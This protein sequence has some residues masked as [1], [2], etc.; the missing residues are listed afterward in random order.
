MIYKV[1]GGEII[2]LQD[3]PAGGITV[4]EVRAVEYVPDPFDALDR[5]L[6]ALLAPEPH[7][8]DAR[9]ELVAQ[10]L[11]EQLSGRDARILARALEAPLLRLRAAVGTDDF[12]NEREGVLAVDAAFFEVLGEI[13]PASDVEALRSKKRAQ[14]D[15]LAPRVAA[16][17]QVASPG[18]TLLTGQTWI[19]AREGSHG[20]ALVAAWGKWI[21]PTQ[22]LD[23][24]ARALWSRVKA[25][26]DA[27]GGAALPSEALSQIVEATLPVRRA[28]RSNE[29]QGRFEVILRDGRVV[30]QVD[31][32]DVPHARRIGPSLTPEVVEA[33]VGP[34]STVLAQRVFRW[35][36]SDTFE[37]WTAAP[38]GFRP[39]IVVPN[40]LQ[41]LAERVGATGGKQAAQLPEVLDALAALRVDF[42]GT[43]DARILHWSRSPHAPGRPA[44]VVIYPGD[45]LRPGWASSLSRKTPGERER[46]RL[47]PIPR[48]A[49]PPVLDRRL[50]AAE[51]G[52]ALLTMQLLA[53][54]ARQIAEGG[55]AEITDAEWRR[56]ADRVEL[57]RG[58]M[59]RVVDA[60]KQGEGRF[61]ELERNRW[62]LGPAYAT[63]W[64]H[65]QTLGRIRER[66]A[67]RGELISRRRRG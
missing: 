42:N 38:R 40:G 60:W 39:E 35:L 67:Q 7:G 17:R 52:L 21:E 43:G 27:K 9:S 10:A 8:L 14:W 23:F 61:L 54:R 31:A 62:R 26:L 64:K 50:H 28:R 65:L 4:S 49:P 57:D 33:L 11:K 47:V 22:R 20:E 12:W 18:G 13:M 53:E 66:A 25:G 3:L 30:A 36:V 2:I 59:Y 44:E 55:A 34:T 24:L 48:E 19:V 37:R 45:A 63:E 5:T 51:G 56:L 15:Q 41:G 29:A 58:K 32:R 16:A 1:K 46:A 6:A